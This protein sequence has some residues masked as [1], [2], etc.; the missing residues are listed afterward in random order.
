MLVKVAALQLPLG[1]GLTLSEKLTLIKQ[2]PDVVILPEY[3][4]IESHIAD[5]VRAA[6]EAPRYREYLAHLSDELT[7]TIVGGSFIEATAHGLV[8]VCYVFDHGRELGRYE[9]QYPMPGELRA[10]I[11]PGRSIRVITIDGLRLG[12]LICGDVLH[13]EAFANQADDKPD[14]IAIP[15][16]SPY[17]PDDNAL[18]KEGRDERY[19]RQGAETAGSYVVKCGGVGTLFGRPLQ[20]RSLVA[21]PWGILERIELAQEQRMRILTVTL[22]IDELREFRRRQ[23]DPRKSASTVS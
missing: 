12:L 15:T 6:L 13:D 2:R 3:Q 20:G 14:L 9:K 23:T 18:M 1:R 17:R 22:N 21:A 4:L 16:A 19:Y 11:V 10:G 8:N 7:T 5:H